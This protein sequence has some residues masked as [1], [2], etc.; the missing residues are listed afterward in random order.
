MKYETLN[1]TDKFIKKLNGTTVMHEW[2]DEI[3]KRMSNFTC[4]KGGNIIEFGFGM[5]ISANYI[6]QNK[7]NSHTICEINPQ[8]L[9][10]LYEWKKDKENVIIIEGDWF[11]NKDML[12]TYDG[13]FFDTHDDVN[14]GYFFRELIYNISNKGT[15]LTW[16]NNKNTPYFRNQ[17][18]GTEY[19][20]LNINPPENDYFNHKEYFMPK[21]IF[22]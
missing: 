15:R 1:I 20:I 14:N 13:I 3:M 16:W 11:D 5:G 8:I 22:R 7:V 6:Q 21:Y 18:V 4:E 10:N 19:E 9:E 17:P 2:E 12:G